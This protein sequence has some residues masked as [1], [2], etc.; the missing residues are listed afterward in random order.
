MRLLLLTTVSSDPTRL[1][2]CERLIA[3]INAQSS[4]D[5]EVKH[6]LLIQDLPGDKVGESIAREH[7]WVRVH[8]SNQ[9]LSLSKARNI[10][11]E[12]ARNAGDLKVADVVAFPDDDAWYPSPFLAGLSRLFSGSTQPDIFVCRYSMT[13][14][15]TG[16]DMGGADK[17]S[18]LQFVQGASSNTMFIS[19]NIVRQLGP[20]D[21]TLGV[22]T[23]LPGAEDLDYA[24][25]ARL[26]ARTVRSSTMALIGHRD[27]SVSL[28]AKY[29]SAD[30]LVLMRYAKDWSHVVLFGR[31]LMV[32]LY[33]IGARQLSISEW[34]DAVSQSLISRLKLSPHGSRIS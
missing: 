32:G 14:E 3:S 25:R 23:A 7:E 26:K 27:K 2:L 28:K 18:L 17:P 33:L 1:A 6:L 10:L 9:R 30:L 15:P 22:G 13:P 20:F 21:E 8:R 34:A 31:K 24:L 11:L 5:L 4:P 12:L 29:Y 16:A 19:G